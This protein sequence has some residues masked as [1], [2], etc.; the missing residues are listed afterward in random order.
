MSGRKHQ[1]EKE[2]KVDQTVMVIQLV[3]EKFDKPQFPN[4]KN[5]QKLDRLQMDYSS[6]DY[7]DYLESVLELPWGKYSDATISLNKSKKLLDRDHY[8]LKDVKERILEYLSVIKLKNQQKDKDTKM[9]NIL[10]FIGPPGVGKTSLGKS[11]ANALGRNF[12]RASLGGIRD[13]AEIR[14][15]RRTYVGAMSGRIVNGIKEAKSMNPVFMLDEVDKLGADY[16]GDPSAALLEA[17]D[18]EQNNSFTDHYLD[19]PLDLSQVF[20]SH[21]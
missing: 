4:M 3:D 16:R 14:G 6:D 13:E 1:I 12:V 8:G 2:L 5:C 21:R 7:V 15:H 18:P 10:C 19:F 17:L 11:I 9:T 20:H